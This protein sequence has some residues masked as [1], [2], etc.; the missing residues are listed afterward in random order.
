[1]SVQCK[2]F[3]LFASYKTNDIK[4]IKRVDKQQKVK[5]LQLL[6]LF[7]LFGSVD[8]NISLLMMPT[9]KVKDLMTN[10]KCIDENF[11]TSSEVL[12]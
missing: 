12:N 5:D 3:F 9:I 4:K 11:L 6:F 7:I 1:L 8:G 2:F 10:C